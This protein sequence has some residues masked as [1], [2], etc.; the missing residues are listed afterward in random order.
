MRLRSSVPAARSWKPRL[1]KG[2]GATRSATVGRRR[3]SH[4]AE[5]AQVERAETECEDE[6]PHVH[7]A[8][9]P[10]ESLEEFHCKHSRVLAAQPAILRPRSVAASPWPGKPVTCRV[11]LR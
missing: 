3:E 1:I 2:G 7:L 11:D 6:Q 10:V 4:G 5:G 9:D 8:A